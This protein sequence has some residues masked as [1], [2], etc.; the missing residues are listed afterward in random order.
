MN[1][2]KNGLHR[3]HFL[4]PKISELFVLKKYQTLENKHFL[5]ML[6]SGTVTKTT[7]FNA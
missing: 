6:Q 4:Q 3:L 2:N 7:H 5:F 1:Y